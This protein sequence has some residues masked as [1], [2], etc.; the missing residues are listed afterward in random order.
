MDQ[1]PHRKRGRVKPSASASPIVRSLA[2]IPALPTAHGT[3]LKQVLLAASETDSAVTQ[4]ARTSFRSG[5]RAESHIHP[6]MDEHYLFLEGR[7]SMTLGDDRRDCLPGDY[8]LVPAGTAHSLLAL[9]D[10]KFI[11]IGIAYD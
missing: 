8:I 11:T 3:G 7:G 1:E 10:M 5:E 6:T 4:I 2:D 9:T